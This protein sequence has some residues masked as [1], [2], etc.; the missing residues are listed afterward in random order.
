M[1][2][3]FERESV[4]RAVFSGL[5][6]SIAQANALHVEA[7]PSTGFRSRRWRSGAMVTVPIVLA[8][9]MTVSLNLVAPA[10]SAA[11]APKRPA[12]PK[13]E[14]AKTLREILLTSAK[15]NASVAVPSSSYTVVPG[16]SV[17]VIAG[18]YGISTASVLALN[19]LSWKSLI[20][21]GQVLKLS[22]AA[23]RPA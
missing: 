9:A 1:T 23:A 7:G 15:S 14:L 10:D 13:S 3:A 16:D 17:S 19:G 8:G 22:A 4:A 6:P 20:F 11:A 2:D 21:P 5:L 18:R 12:K